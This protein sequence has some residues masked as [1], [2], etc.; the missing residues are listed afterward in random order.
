[1]NQNYQIGQSINQQL[2][3]IK[4]FKKNVENFISPNNNN[5]ANKSESF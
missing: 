3:L 5:K 2:C 1:M 4:M